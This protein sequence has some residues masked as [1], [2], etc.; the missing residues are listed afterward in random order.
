MPLMTAEQYVNFKMNSHPTN[1]AVDNYQMARLRC[2]DFVFNTIGNGIIEMSDFVAAISHH[3]KESC[4]PYQGK[5]IPATR[6]WVPYPN[7]K[8]MH[9]LVW[10]PC[11]AENLDKSWV[12]AAIFFYQECQKF[13]DGANVHLYH[14]ACPLDSDSEEWARRI[15][16]IKKSFVKHLGTDNPVTESHSK[17]VELYGVE[18]DGDVEAFLRRRW[19]KELARIRDYLHGTLATLEFFRRRRLTTINICDI[20]QPQ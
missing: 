13:F 7:F 10:I 2:F 9:S 6:A 17:V 11:L 20:I 3:D 19:A 15:A 16:N 8:I 5:Y 12:E 4:E 18:Y 1:Y 14:Y